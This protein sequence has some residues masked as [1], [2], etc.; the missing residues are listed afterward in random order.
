[1]AAFAIL[2]LLARLSR[3]VLGNVIGHERHQR[4]AFF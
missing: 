4:R 2:I 3:P 1:M